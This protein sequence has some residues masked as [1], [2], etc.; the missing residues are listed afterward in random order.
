[1]VKAILSSHASM[2][3]Y[4]SH[5][6]LGPLQNGR[7]AALI[8]TDCCRLATIRA[9]TGTPAKAD[10]RCRRENIRRPVFPETGRTNYSHQK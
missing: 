2:D 6:T 7:H 9:K 5:L 3:A 10:S 1:M 4:V 8:I